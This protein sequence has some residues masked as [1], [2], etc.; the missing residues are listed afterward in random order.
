MPVDVTRLTSADVTAP[1]RRS[2]VASINCPCTRPP[3][4]DSS[5]DST[6]TLAVRSASATAC[7]TA[8][9]H[10]ARSTTAPA[11]TPRDWIWL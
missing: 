10:S 4:T 3:D 7:R 8:C 6:R 2:A 1:P 5:T 9:S 11:L